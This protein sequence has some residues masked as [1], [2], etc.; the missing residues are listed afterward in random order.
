MTVYVDSMRAPFRGLIMCHMI[1]DEPEE[2]RAM[3][4]LIGVARRWEQEGHFD[5]GLSKRALAVAGGAVEITLR[6][7]GC[8]N[9]RRRVTGSLGPPEEAERWAREHLRQQRRD[10]QPSEAP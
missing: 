8:M 7:C 6:Q 10:N 1:A 2:L 3:A 9:M 4:D 5:I